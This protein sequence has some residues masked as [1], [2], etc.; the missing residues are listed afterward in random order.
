MKKN[1]LMNN[2]LKI[3]KNNYVFN[4]MQAMT[5]SF[6]LLTSILNF[7]GKYIMH[8]NYK[9]QFILFKYMLINFQ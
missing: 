9:E 5:Q 7:Y 4:L 6:H 8:K 3:K 1:F 2:D